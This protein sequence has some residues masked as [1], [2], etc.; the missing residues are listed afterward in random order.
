MDV[1][2]QKRFAVGTG[3]PFSTTDAILA[4]CLRIAGVPEAPWSPRHIYNEEILFKAGGGLKDNEGNVT[5][6]SRFAGLS[7]FEAAKAAWNARKTAMS[8]IK[9]RI[10]YHFEH[11]SETAYLIAAYRDQEKTVNEADGDAAEFIREIMRKAA[12]RLNDGE[13]VMDER[14]AL[15]RILCV[16]LKTRTQYVNRWKDA[17]PI[18]HIKGERKTTTNTV[19][20]HRTERHIMDDK[21]VP[22]NASDETLRKMKMI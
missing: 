13:Q 14:E 15:L 22:V 21:F 9:G 6:K 17:V 12:G 3:L 20:A 19:G 1:E 18:L 7:I 8:P 11:T 2:D 16:T 10:E 4:Q 5:R